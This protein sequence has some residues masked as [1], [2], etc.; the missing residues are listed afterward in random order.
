MPAKVV[1]EVACN[2][3]AALQMSSPIHSGLMAASDHQL[4]RMDSPTCLFHGGVLMGQQCRSRRATGSWRVGILGSA[5]APAARPRG[6]PTKRKP[7][8]IQSARVAR[9]K[10][11]L[12][13]GFYEEPD[14]LKLALDRMI[15]HEAFRC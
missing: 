11:R 15:A 13:V 14:I 1:D 10:A 12:A 9:V 2:T 4:T 6:N 8:P 3:V 5:I 7:R